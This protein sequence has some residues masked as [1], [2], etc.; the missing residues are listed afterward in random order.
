[1]VK[2]KEQLERVFTTLDAYTAGYLFLNNFTPELI[3]QGSK[4][5]FVFS[6]SDDLY[7]QLSNYNNG[8]TVE[9]VRFAGAIKNLKSQIFSLRRNNGHELSTLR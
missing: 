1:L 9:A 7:S 5:V 3:Q 4:V 8:A 6:A 2:N